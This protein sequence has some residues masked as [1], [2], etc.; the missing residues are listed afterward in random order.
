MIGGAYREGFCDG[1]LGR[2]SQNPYNYTQFL[3]MESYN[4]GFL[5]G[6]ELRKQHRIKLIIE[7]ETA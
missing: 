6:M 5:R 7:K 1:L 4:K 2:K 3:S